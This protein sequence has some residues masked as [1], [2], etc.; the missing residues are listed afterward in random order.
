MAQG[1]GRSHH[2]AHVPSEVVASMLD[3]LIAEGTVR[4]EG[5]DAASGERLFNLPTEKVINAIENKLIARHGWAQ[6]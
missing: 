2:R 1:K 3:E 6:S 5:Y 4:V